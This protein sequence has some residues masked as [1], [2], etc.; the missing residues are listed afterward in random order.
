VSEKSN[1]TVVMGC[2][3]P[4]WSVLQ[5]GSQHLARQFAG[6]GWQVHYFSAP[7]SPI[8]LPLLFS[9]EVPDRFRCACRNPAIHENGR[10]FSYIPFSLIAPDGRALLRSRPVT[11]HWHKTMLPPLKQML[12]GTRLDRFDLLYIDNLSYH[13]LPD[14]MPDAKI[15]FRVMDMHERFSGWKGRALALA[16][17]IAARADLTVYSAKDLKFYVDSLGAANSMLVPNGVDLEAFFP[18]P[19]AENRPACLAQIP[20]PIFLY[21]GMIDSRLDFTLIRTTARRLPDISFVFAGPMDRSQAIADMPSNVYF[22]GPV[23]HADLPALM[24]SAAAGLIPF[25]VRNRMD[26]IR[27]IRPLK[28]FEY[29]AAGIPVISARWPEIQELQS[30]AWFYED[31]DQF[32]RLAAMALG[33]EDFDPAAARDFA[34]Q[35]DWKHS[36]KKMTKALYRS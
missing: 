2:S 29:L 9:H 23:P 14:L 13:F 4:Y 35:F 5:V 36:F 20:D 15:V 17:K 1:K 19:Q 11:H 3:H 34:G 28:L 6:N 10:I 30:P 25:D 31:A 8:H 16:E 12:A 27:G 24:H 21:T 7:V 18:G 22:T 33:K 32:T 26:A